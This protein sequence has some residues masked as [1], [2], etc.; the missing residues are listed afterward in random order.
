MGGHGDSPGGG[1]KPGGG[2]ISWGAAPQGTDEAPQ[3]RP[4]GAYAGMGAGD[5]AYTQGDIWRLY[6]SG[7]S[8]REISART[9]K[10]RHYVHNRIVKARE[11]TRNQL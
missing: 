9:G 1:D 5:A 3:A 7:L 8:I 6:E 2:D 11:C 4:G 10:G